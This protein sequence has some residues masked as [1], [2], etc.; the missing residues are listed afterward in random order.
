MIEIPTPTEVW[1]IDWDAIRE[2]LVLFGLV[3]GVLALW[4]LVIQ[5][6]EPRKRLIS[7]KTRILGHRGS[8]EE[9]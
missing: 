2:W 3:A 5:T 8:D 9:E 4:Q 6:F 7:L 1:A